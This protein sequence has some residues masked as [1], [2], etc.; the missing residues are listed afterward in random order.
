M[1]DTNEQRT[2]STQTGKRQ[3]TAAQEGASEVG[4]GV[5]VAVPR[6]IPHLFNNKYTVRLT[7]ADSYRH[8]VS[9]GG[10]A[11]GRTW[12][13]NSIYDPDVTGTG[14]Q[15]ILRD[16]WASQYD[17][18]A[19]LATH[20]KVNIYNANWDAVQYTAVGTSGQR[21]GSIAATLLPS[22]N[23]S[24][25]AAMQSGYPY[26]AMEMKNGVS[27]IL[28]PQEIWRYEN[29]YT[30][31][32]WLIDAKDEDTDTTWTAVG[33]NPA[34][35]RYLGLSLNSLYPGALTGQSEQAYVTALVT[36]TIDYDVQFTQL[37]PALR[38]SPS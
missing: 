31:G 23:T 28:H 2:A 26:P 20:V 15:P 36:I 6:T 9:M 32:D 34:L 1:S 21:I 30:Q 37:T 22:T 24:E 33:G 14:H 7:Y 27:S 38:Y 8:E 3:R 12:M 10:G 4:Q 16:L 25:I 17:Y 35:P 5:Q 29:T 13:L 18:Y 19:V 11:S